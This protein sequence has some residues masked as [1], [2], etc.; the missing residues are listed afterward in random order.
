MKLT[1][2]KV[3]LERF[4]HRIGQPV[5][6]YPRRGKDLIAF[7]SDDS[8][9]S[10]DAGY[11]DAAPPPVIHASECRVS[12]ELGGQESLIGQHESPSVSSSGDRYSR[13]P[14]GGEYA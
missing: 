14:S 2:I 4:S 11:N 3:P 8:I 6:Y 1:V 7:S 12:R 10:L 9:S 5:M 13:R